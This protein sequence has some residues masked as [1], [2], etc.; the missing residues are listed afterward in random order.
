MSLQATNNKLSEKPEPSQHPI[1]K[2]M[3]PLFT[4]YTSWEL[5]LDPGHTVTIAAITIHTTA[6]VT[7]HEQP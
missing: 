7:T 5:E 3:G 1:L 2:L 4:Q 6:T